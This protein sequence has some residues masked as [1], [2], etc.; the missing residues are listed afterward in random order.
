[1]NEEDYLK[2]LKELYDNYRI[3]DGSLD[4][5]AR[6]MKVNEIS[7][8]ISEAA[9]NFVR[10][11]DETGYTNLLGADAELGVLLNKEDPAE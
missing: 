11:E 9:W 5:H 10:G 1:M 8:L 4:R 7:A 2:R 6:I 3:Q